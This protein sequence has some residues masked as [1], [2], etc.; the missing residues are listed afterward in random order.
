VS[1]VVQDERAQAITGARVSID[2][3]T[4][5]LTDEVGLYLLKGVAPGRRTLKAEVAGRPPA[6]REIDVPEGE[7]L[8]GVVLVLR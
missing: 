2:G 8:I 7:E 1:G 6:T 3:G 4:A 5:V